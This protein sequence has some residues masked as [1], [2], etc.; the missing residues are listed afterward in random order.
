MVG[1][2]KWQLPCFPVM[3]RAQKRPAIPHMYTGND[4]KLHR[5]FAQNFIGRNRATNLE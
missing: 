1:L 3:T 4:P 2:R 5:E